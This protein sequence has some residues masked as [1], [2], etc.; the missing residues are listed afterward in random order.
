MRMIFEEDSCLVP[1]GRTNPGAAGAADIGRAC[2][3]AAEKETSGRVRIFAAHS[4]ERGARA[5]AVGFAAGCAEGGCEVIAG[6]E[7]SAWAA[8]AA[9]RALGCNMGCH[10]HTEISPLFR[11]FA[12]DGLPLRAAEEERILSGLTL[13]KGRNASGENGSQPSLPYSH[14]GNIKEF[15]GAGDVYVSGLRSRLGGRLHGINPDV[16]SPSSAV[17]G[18]AMQAL[19]GRGDPMGERIAFHI[20]SDSGRLSAFSDSTGYVFRDKLVMLCCR[21]LF[22]KGADAAF[23]GRPPRWLERMAEKYGRKVISCGREVCTGCGEPSEECAR[24]RELAASQG[25][26]GDG[27]ALMMET[28]ET[29]RLRKE[30]LKEAIASLPPAATINRYIPADRPSRLL[31]RLCSTEGNGVL[32]DSGRGLVT[33]RPVRTGKGLMLGVESFSMETAA[34]LCDFYENSI[35]QLIRN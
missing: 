11:F 16:Y 13:K 12:A 22:E 18:E 21:G 23:C 30:P 7:C 3:M 10:I 5:L 4:G 25:F 15:T 28:L 2:A 32:S 19:E 33:V 8:A 31:E 24:A 17:L 27:I 26:T 29:L 6:G 34:E 1:A 9:V 14:Y 20:G 35:K